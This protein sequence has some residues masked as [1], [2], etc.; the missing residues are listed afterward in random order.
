[1]SGAGDD[2]G[3][4]YDDDDVADE[5]D[6][7]DLNEDDRDPTAGGS[8]VGGRA[9]EPNPLADIEDDQTGAGTGPTS[10]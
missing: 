3:F 7:V 5:T 1:M 10:S 8:D 2:D 6:D 9:G 4:Q